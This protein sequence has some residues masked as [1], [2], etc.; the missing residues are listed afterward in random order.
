MDTQTEKHLHD[1]TVDVESSVSP[2]SQ[3][4]KSHAQNGRGFRDSMPKR[5]PLPWQVPAPNPESNVN[6][7]GSTPKTQR[8]GTSLGALFSF[9]WY[10]Y[11]SQRKKR[12]FL[13]IGAIAI[14]LL[15]ALIIGLS[16]GLTVGKK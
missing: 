12:R 5:K 13:I 10:R 1:S 15:L 8:I 9:D 3:P 16:V 7:T 11:A 14:L 4:P 2:I 6:I